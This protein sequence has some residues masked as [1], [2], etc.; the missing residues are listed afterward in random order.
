M[1]RISFLLLGAYAFI[2]FGCETQENEMAQEVQQK[3]QR[4]ISGQGQVGPVDRSTDPFVRPRDS[5]TTT[6]YQ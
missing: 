2:G 5:G 6:E 3:F 4:G 1:K